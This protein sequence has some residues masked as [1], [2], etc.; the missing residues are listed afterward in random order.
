MSE[1]RT[2]RLVAE[3]SGERRVRWAFGYDAIAR[4]AG[5]S[6]RAVDDA[7]VNG[8]LVPASLLSTALWIAL[9]RHGAAVRQIAGQMRR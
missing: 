5:V 7:R 9:R 4:A 8:E 3:D 1:R 6:R 2:V